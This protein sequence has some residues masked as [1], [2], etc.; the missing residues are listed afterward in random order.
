MSNI[1]RAF[2][3]A[4]RNGT[5]DSLGEVTRQGQHSLGSPVGYQP[6]ELIHSGSHLSGGSRD[7]PAVAQHSRSKKRSLSLRM[8]ASI[9]GALGR[10]IC[11]SHGGIDS[12]RRSPD[13]S[14]CTV[15]LTGDPAQTNGAILGNGGGEVAA[16]SVT[17]PT[18]RPAHSK[19]YWRKAAQV[20]EMQRDHAECRAAYLREI[21]ALRDQIR[22][23]PC[24]MEEAVDVTFYEPLQHM[25][26]ECQKLVQSCVEE[27]IK[28]MFADADRE[29]SLLHMFVQ[30]RVSKQAA[31][32]ED[33]LKERDRR[34]KKLIDERDALAQH[35]QLLQAEMRKKIDALENDLRI[36]SCA[37]QNACEESAARLA[38]SAEMTVSLADAQTARQGLLE[39]LALAEEQL[40]RQK[41]ELEKKEVEKKEVEKEEDE[42][43][44]TGKEEQEEEEG[45]RQAA[46]GAF[47]GAAG[48][49]MSDT[50][51]EFGSL[52]VHEESRP[53]L[54]GAAAAVLMT[55]AE[56][57]HGHL[58]A[59]DT[60]VTTVD[61]LTVLERF[62][63]QFDAE[64]VSEL[65]GV[66]H[67]GASD[68]SVA[69]LLVMRIRSA[70]RESGLLRSLCIA[71]IETISELLEVLRGKAS[72]QAKKNMLLKQVEDATARC[73]AQLHQ[74]FLA[75]QRAWLELEEPRQQVRHSQ[76]SFS[77]SA[78][79][80][81]PA[82]ASTA[83]ETVLAASV[84]ASTSELVG[85]RRAAPSLHGNGDA[86]SDSE[87]KLPPKA[88][89][90]SHARMSKHLPPE[91]FH[92]CD[93]DHH[94][95]A[96]EHLPG[97]THKI[98]GHGQ[99]ETVAAPARPSSRLLKDADLSACDLEQP[100]TLRTVST[101]SNQSR[102]RSNAQSPQHAL[103]KTSS[104]RLDDNE[105]LPLSPGTSPAN[106]F[107]GTRN[108]SLRNADEKQSRGH[109]SSSPERSNSGPPARL[110][111]PRSP[112][113]PSASSPTSPLG[114]APQSTLFL[115]GSATIRHKC[116][117]VQNATECQGR[118]RSL[119]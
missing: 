109:K 111:S 113:V 42:S 30:Q 51:A 81:E 115:T 31:I 65:T 10:F 79:E 45:R 100:A 75:A 33:L 85:Q 119:P 5:T 47:D 40:E 88:E 32:W 103:M 80:D 50:I 25:D 46:A 94:S 67:M 116:L 21:T 66:L 34:E 107:G 91:L 76:T 2:A 73:R 68:L 110:K 86:C 6:R 20:A 53:L 61:L 77:L 102:R 106:K 82:S 92:S 14:G 78:G 37:L 26:E 63:E 27:K 83:F 57:L 70:R 118:R 54:P 96:Q 98:I 39:R 69:K 35:V 1:F 117:E 23:V 28:T 24:G 114:S 13:L 17:Q 16:E 84:E 71:A 11:H 58:V 19:I 52:G 44:K 104:V 108:G 90:V 41:K 56:E 49:A 89:L 4:H 48:T 9:G 62:G 64:I 112:R 97:S 38:E 8:K 3:A 72:L 29:D 93:P 87:Y 55:H 15:D 74:C 18:R 105:D 7:S 22:G 101:S 95:V 99:K 60:T 12:S 59:K 36:K 43:Q